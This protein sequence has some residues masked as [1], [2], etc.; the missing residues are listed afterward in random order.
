ME[1]QELWPRIKD[2]V[3]AALDRQLSERQ[4]FVAEACSGNEPLRK[5]VESLLAAYKESDDFSR[6][7]ECIPAE[8]LA[9]FDAP[10]ATIGPYRLIRELGAGGMGQVWLAE[11]TVPVRR[12]VALK[13][14]R[15]GIYGHAV[16]QRFLAERQSL[17]S[18][19][20]P[21]IAKVFDAGATEAG[22]P[23][24]VMEYV[25]GSPI[26]AYCD[27][28]KLDI[29]S[30]LQLFLRVCEGVQHA[31]QKA[32]I[33]RDL[34]PS[35]ILVIEVD[36]KPYPRLIDFGLAK[37]IAAS[38]LVEAD[39]EFATQVGV[40]LGTPAYMSPEQADPGSG[41]IDTRSDVYSLGVVLY[42]LLTG[43]L[44]Y[45]PRRLNGQPLDEFLRQLRE[46][47]TPRPSQRVSDK[48]A[49]SGAQAQARSAEIRSL[50]E[51]LRG[52]L[53]WITLKALE[54]D[55]DRRY[56]APS[57]LA[58]DIE[59]YLENRPVLARPASAGYRLSKYVRRNRLA[60]AVVSGI[61]IL[62]AAFAIVQA[63]QLHRIT[64]ERDRARR[65]RD[66][67]D[68]LTAFMTNMFNVSNPSEARGNSITAREV[69]DKAARD[70]PAQLKQDPE[71]Q[72]QMM[73]V[74][75]NVYS[76]LGLYS[77][78]EPLLREAA[79]ISA[80]T[81]GTESE[82]ALEARRA[83]GWAL[84]DL[85]RLSEAEHNDRELV[86]TEQ[87]VLGAHHRKTL[88]T[89]SDLAW[90]LDAEG[91]YPEAVRIARTTLEAQQRA[92]GRQDPD[93]LLLL[94]R[95]SMALFDNRQI[96]EAE[97]F[98]REAVELDRKV[99]G[100]EDQTT[101]NILHGLGLVLWHEGRLAEAE[102]VLT[103][104]LSAQRRIL[105]PLHQNTIASMDTLAVVLQNE[106][107]LAAAEALYREAYQAS[108]QSLG[109]DH[110][111]T[112]M[113]LG[114]LAS[115]IGD[116]G[117]Q[118]EAEQLDRQVLAVRRRTLGA[119]H[120]D[121]TLAMFNLADAVAAQGGY[122]EAAGI[123]RETLE[124]ERKKL[125][126]SASDTLDTMYCLASALARGR[127]REEAIAVLRQAVKQ[128]MPASTSK[129]NIETD[130]DFKSLRQDP[131]FASLV[132]EAKAHHPPENHSK[133]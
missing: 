58:A 63:L 46:T 11:Q 69:L 44:P 91:Q 38:T 127:K 97:L 81:L 84:F 103:E 93:A 14:I 7:A 110:H 70:I 131:R 30:R 35:N 52:D 80:D 128:G 10:P 21:S 16:L 33:H 4:A 116:E 3:G 27:S 65:E 86:A 18:M 82:Q 77:K 79:K 55:R 51:S 106:H 19:D 107:K 1:T 66:R 123:Y 118:K 13:L 124:I 17:A 68:R 60:V 96:K 75:G 25:D 89:W 22:Q 129:Y 42:E 133:S 71:L 39:Q 31:H 57:A 12:L 53:D 88:A 61:V 8:I 59:N 15:T 36:G 98:A 9:D 125:G 95:L 119:D 78:A 76:K 50:S 6:Q 47:E 37:N 126:P 121:T 41:G 64:A 122:E 62:L 29:R 87:R 34:K 85:G 2:I 48:Q 132:A 112:L 49:L 67:A 45:T 90:I 43:S 99:L 73:E 32:I 108:L 120:P 104:T 102:N 113:A 56:N 111:Q 28:R 72:A 74:M 54:K 26:N 5:E 117:R 40:F 83:L 100:P 24:L 105:G 23:Y 109:P 101:L 92:F 114:N 20:H 94:G 130:P 115:L